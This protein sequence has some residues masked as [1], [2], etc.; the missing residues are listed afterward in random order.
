MAEAKKEK[1]QK[2]ARNA[3]EQLIYSKITKATKMKGSLRT[4][5]LTPRF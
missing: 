1:P 4:R 5:L 2:N 3:K